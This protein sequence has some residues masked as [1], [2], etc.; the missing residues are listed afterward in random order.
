V[1]KQA[2]LLII[3]FSVF[4]SLTIWF[5][6]KPAD[7]DREILTT[8]S[9]DKLAI[10][11]SKAAHNDSSTA[12]DSG[13]IKS[14][15]D[16]RHYSSI[17]LS[18]SL[19]VLLISDP[20]TDKAAASLDV[21][22]GS[23]N[24]PEEFLGLAHFL[25]HMLFLGTQ[26]YPNPDEYQKY[27]S[28][29][30][31][32]H[33]AY[34]SLEHTNYF[35]DIQSGHFE[36]ALDRFSEQFTHP[37]FNNEY[38]ER[39]ANAVHSEYTSKS[40]DD[41]R[42]FFSVIKDT[43]TDAHPYSK[44]SVG[45]L[46]TLKDHQDN[47]LRPALLDFYRQNYS[48]NNMR[49]VI[50]GKESI[51]TL[52]AW[53]KNKFS[54]I[55]N[56]NLP[57]SRID[58]DFFAPGFL[59]AKVEIQSVMDK[60]SM[61]I[62]FP[63][64]S[65]SRHKNSQPIS[66]LANLIGHEGKGSLLS[67]LKAEQ[68]VDSLSA[69][70][71]FDTQ[72]KSIFML[73]MS[74]TKKGLANQDRILE[75]IFSYIDLLKNE[76]IKRM[77]FDEQATML[78]TSFHY[79]EK[80]EPIHFVSALSSALH[81]SDSQKI[82]FE[83]YDLT[84]FKPALY[85]D[86]LEQLVPQNMLLVISAKDISGDLKSSWYQAPYKVTPLSSDLKE[87]LSAPIKIA[88]LKVPEKNIFIPEN[89]NLL[90]LA[91]AE[92]PINLLDTDSLEVWHYPSNEFGTPKSNLFV[93]IRS[94]EAMASADALNK[95][96]LLVALLKDALNEF[97]YPAYLAGLHYE[98]YNHMR[99]V[100]IKISGYSDKQSVLLD[101]I[102][103]T[104]KSAEFSTSRFDI[105][106]ERL[107]R[108]LQNVKD[109]KPFQQAI[110]KTQNILLNPS[111][112]EA[113]RL[114]FL[115]KTSLTDVNSFKSDF[116][117]KLDIA[118]LSSGNITGSSAEKISQLIT[119]RLLDSSAKVKVD[120]SKVTKL[121]GT[122]T[123]YKTFDVEHPDT[124]FV[125]YIQGSND[126]IKERAL[127]LLLTQAISSEFYGQIRT[128]KQLGY[129]VFATDFSMLEVPGIAFIVQSPNTKGQQLL[130]ETQSF[131]NAQLDTIKA[132]TSSDI[133]RFQAAVASRLLKKDNTLYEKTNGFW[134]EIDTLNFDFDTKD[135]LAKAVESITVKEL[136]A[137]LKSL[138][139][140]KGQSIIIHSQTSDAVDDK[141][142][143]VKQLDLKLMTEDTKSELNRF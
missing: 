108:K 32:A 8:A 109:K 96:E 13:I 17:T 141:L 27:I 70:D 24:D 106:K 93:T 49:L 131:L 90:A 89:T 6:N 19:Q 44:F 81:Y 80:S 64:P 51:E 94:P 117:S 110:A 69:G 48:A 132:L 59:P 100:T 142:E 62:G 43:L 35:F 74:L 26:K 56:H 33:N 60:R 88:D 119:N 79:Q 57:I 47:K 113:E 103:T 15:N 65:A 16:K 121:N 114:T 138:L 107:T 115:E 92:K 140:N 99:G 22:T 127:F 42:R 128:E 66:Y 23:A 14:P 77:Y 82:L 29:H 118:M 11:S 135:Q 31:G 45:N 130:N 3:V 126:S 75:M 4:S 73:N 21:N 120:R 122:Q 34:T 78:R 67:A 98:L 133:E 86:Y 5:I 102:L 2:I 55:P 52:E 30:G 87:K 28:D 124:G 18:N 83:S 50:L 101:K 105:M 53:V 112:E 143:K 54:D 123:W 41:G 38:V 25:E 76:G 91:I 7:N 125:Y 97:S 134:K 12:L 1:S 61:T 104:L 71:Q 85:L 58:T 95:S 116:L 72:L 111:W 9:P 36:E 136:H 46:D 68:L 84:N 40:K 137:H 129:I 39:E 63:I 10:N 20:K 139:E 37:L